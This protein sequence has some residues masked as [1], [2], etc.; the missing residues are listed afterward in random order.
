MI[1]TVE[2]TGVTSAPKRAKRIGSLNRWE[3]N[4][5]ESV[6]WAVIAENFVSASFMQRQ[7]KTSEVLRAKY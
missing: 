6:I 5:A 3:E 7:E 1:S 4:E 2:E